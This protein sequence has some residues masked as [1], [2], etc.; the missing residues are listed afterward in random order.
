V[1]VGHPKHQAFYNIC[2]LA[3][4][5]SNL[6]SIASASAN[7][8]D[9]NIGSHEQDLYSMDPLVTDVNEHMGETI[10]HTCIFWS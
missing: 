3:H 4:N 7:E 1:Y 5:C 9:L 6:D 8:Q 10:D 2:Y